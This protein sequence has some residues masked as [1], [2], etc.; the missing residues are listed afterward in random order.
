LTGPSLASLAQVALR[1]LARGARERVFIRVRLGLLSSG[2]VSYTTEIKVRFG[3]E[4]HARIVY[5]PRFFDFFHQAM[6]DFFGAHGHPYRDVLTKDGAGW[7]AV[8]AEADFKSPA[9]FGDVLTMEL[10]I[11][12]LGEKSVTFA[13]RATNEEDG[14]REIVT[15]KVTCVCVSMDTFRA[16]PIPDK[17][18]ALFEK[19]RSP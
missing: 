10:V 4:D 6:E 2:L 13:Y 14:G 17:Y 3:D 1:G 11:E 8:H 9:R 18:R 12:E 16:Q 5:Y 7:P 15:G 19:H